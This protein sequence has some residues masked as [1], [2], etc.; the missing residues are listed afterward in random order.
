MAD[1]G[2]RGR[3]RRRYDEDH[4][5]E[6]PIILRYEEP[7]VLEDT[8]QMQRLRDVQLVSDYP[9]TSVD[10]SWNVFRRA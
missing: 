6:Q 4:N 3:E 1:R 10:D 8:E 7:S 9:P 5:D 2:R